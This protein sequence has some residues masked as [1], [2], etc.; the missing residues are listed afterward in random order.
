MLKDTYKDSIKCQSLIT[1]PPIIPIFIRSWCYVPLTTL[2]QTRAANGGLVVPFL[3]LCV[4][5]EASM[6]ARPSHKPKA[7]E[8]FI[9]EPMSEEAALKPGQKF[10]T[11]TPGNG[12]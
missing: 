3:I 8:I 4:R 12:E 10:P 2:F 5:V 6:P 11:P 1:F 9:I 7:E